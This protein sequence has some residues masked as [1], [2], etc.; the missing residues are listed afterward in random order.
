MLVAPALPMQARS[1]VF[2]FSFAALV[3]LDLGRDRRQTGGNFMGKRVIAALWAAL[4]AIWVTGAKAEEVDLALVLAVDV[5][6][7]V[8]EEEYRLQRQGYADAFMHPAVISAIRGGARGRIAVVYVQWGGVQYQ[9]VAV[10]WTVVSDANSGRG[11]AE[12]IL[13]ASRSYIRGTS[14]SG[15]IDYSTTQFAL[16]PHAATRQV[17]DVSGDGVNNSGRPPQFARD[18]ALAQN[19]TINGLVINDIVPNRFGWSAYQEPLEEH[20]RSHVIGG[21]G[22]FVIAVDGFE[23]FSHAILNK[24]IREISA[25]P[26]TTR[27]AGFDRPELRIAA[28][29][30]PTRAE[31][32]R[33]HSAE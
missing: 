22:A 16:N 17:I 12:G 28:P 7:S 18:A 15:A 26:P 13:A 23:S 1:E 33:I 4:L 9:R 24:L 30:D 29:A 3:W 20:Y 14:I 5:S 2:L 32:P 19:I 10:P 31:L 11:F 6:G 27:L 25:I 21:P 8:D